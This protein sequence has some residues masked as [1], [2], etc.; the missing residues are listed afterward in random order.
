MCQ[1]LCQAVCQAVCQALS[2]S[3]PGRVSGIVRQC[4]SGSVSGI[5]RQCVAQLIARN[6][7]PAISCH[8]VL[9]EAAELQ[10][11]QRLEA[12]LCQQSRHRRVFCKFSVMS[13]VP[14]GFQPTR[15]AGLPGRHFVFWF[16]YY[17]FCIF[18]LSAGQLDG[19]WQGCLA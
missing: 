18:C 13:F 11:I 1:A 9:D 14:G 6:G 5:A 3:V 7:R 10:F 16:L 15:P 17:G 2:G 12:L 4:V 19:A 8:N